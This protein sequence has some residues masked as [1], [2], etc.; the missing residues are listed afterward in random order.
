MVSRV[1]GSGPTSPAQL[2]ARERITIG[3]VWDAIDASGFQPANAQA[4]SGTAYLEG[5]DGQ[6]IRLPNQSFMDWGIAS[7][8]LLAILNTWGVHPVVSRKYPVPDRVNADDANRPVG[9]RYER[10]INH[11]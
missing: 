1:R 11:T 6:M 10:P 3:D 7:D 4:A 5:A 9:E 2:D 8:D